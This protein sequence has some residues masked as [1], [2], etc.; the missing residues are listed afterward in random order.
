[1]KSVW[2]KLGDGGILFLS[3][4]VVNAAN[5]GLNLA[6]GRFLGPEDFAEANILATLVLVIS[7][8]AVGLQLAT[9]K[10]VAELHAANKIKERN[11]FFLWIKKQGSKVTLIGSLILF[12]CTPWIATFLQF[13]SSLPLF[14]LFS[15]IPFYFH[16]SIARGYYQGICSFRKLAGTYISEMIGRVLPTIALLW[17]SLTLGFPFSTEI[18]A[19]GFFLSFLISFWYSRIK[20]QGNPQ[21][22]I[23]KKPVFQFL[24]IIGIYELSQILINNS[25]VLLVKHYFDAE[26][27]GLYASLALIGRVVYFATWTLVTLLFPKVI[28]KEQK[29]EKHQHLFY[30]SLLIV[31][32]IGALITAL[33]FAADTWIIQILFGAEYLSIAPL[34]WK[35]A[36]ATS[37]FACANVFAYYYMSLNSYWPVLISILGGL[38]QVCLISVFHAD[39]LQVIHVQISLMSVLLLLMIGFHMGKSRRSTKVQTQLSYS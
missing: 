27:A 32:G 33:C 7:F 38:L 29:G 14:V 5:Y 18:V 23:N 35:Y 20:I 39:M 8:I 22:K 25:D 26:Q 19:I 13:K 15:T 1:M 28:E 4:L 11:A 34:L 12:A 10:F 24:F 2:N 16:M 6:L 30:G 3:T 17:I 9:S 31:A 36:V 21:Q 37:L